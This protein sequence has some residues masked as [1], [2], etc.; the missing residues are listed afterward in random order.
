MG[1]LRDKKVSPLAE[2]LAVHE[3]TSGVAGP[4]KLT[5]TRPEALA[6]RTDATNGLPFTGHVVTEAVAANLKAGT[7]LPLFRWA[8]RDAI[9]AKR[10]LYLDVSTDNKPGRSL[11]C[12]PAVMKRN[13]KPA[14]PSQTT[15]ADV[16]GKVVKKK[17]T[18]LAKPATYTHEVMYVDFDVQIVGYGE[19]DGIYKL[20][21]PVLVDANN[22]ATEEDQECV[23]SL[24]EFELSDGAPKEVK[25]KAVKDFVRS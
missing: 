1:N 25:Q 5:I 22:D 12:I 15:V 18:P 23:R 2:T 14:P 6:T 8:E 9:H 16:D 19:F 11:V 21:R 24:T 13:P 4:P 17:K 10:I 3:T 7:V 20:A